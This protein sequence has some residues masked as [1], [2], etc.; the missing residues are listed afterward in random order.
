MLNFILA[1]DL[2][3][4]LVVADEYWFE[5][6]EWL[7][8]QPLF[9]VNG[10]IPLGATL[11]GLLLIYGLTRLVFRANHSEGMTGIFTFVMTA[12]VVLTLIGIYFRG[13]NMALV[14]PF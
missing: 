2:V 8:S 11:F 9:V 13:P 4:L 7:P 6:S 10:L 3:P 1:I 5:L 14:L 12:L